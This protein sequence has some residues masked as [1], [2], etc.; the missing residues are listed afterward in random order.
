MPEVAGRPEQVKYQSIKT[1][2]SHTPVNKQPRIESTRERERE[3]QR[4]MMTKIC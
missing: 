1:E 4:E 2:A 3:R